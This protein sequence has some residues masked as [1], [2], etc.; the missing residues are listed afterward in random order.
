MPA[1]DPIR[2]TLVVDE[3]PV[4]GVDDEVVL[5]A[6]RIELAGELARMVVSTGGW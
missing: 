3:Q 6:R 5:D 2:A 1:H 4:V